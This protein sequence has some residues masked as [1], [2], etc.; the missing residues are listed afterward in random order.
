MQAGLAAERA[1]S[2]RIRMA[3]PSGS[4]G[5]ATRTRIMAAAER[6]FAA[7]GFAAVSMRR[8]ATEAGVQAGTIYL[9][10]TDKQTLLSDL[11]RAHMAAVLAGWARSDPGGEAGARLAAFVRFHVGFHIDRPDAVF[12]AYMELRALAPENFAAI[13]GLRRQYETA[14]EDIL[15]QG[16]AEAGMAPQD[17]RLATLAIIA[18]LTGVTTWYREGGR[19]SREA[20]VERYIRLVAGAVGM[21]MD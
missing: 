20:V 8:I 9:Y 4:D 14:L 18:M 1:F 5:Q 21:A 13:E 12:I 6:L 17:T 7:H 19:L 10:V 3:R 15:T 11:M 16:Q 2:Y